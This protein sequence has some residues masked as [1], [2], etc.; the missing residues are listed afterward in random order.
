MILRPVR[1]TS[2]EHPGSIGILDFSHLRKNY[3]VWA[4]IE[5]FSVGCGLLVAM[6]APL[7]QPQDYLSAHLCP[8]QG[9]SSTKD[10]KHVAVPR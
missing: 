5:S 7:L 1:R 9:S 2:G 10:G 8:L 4:S 6:L 3:G